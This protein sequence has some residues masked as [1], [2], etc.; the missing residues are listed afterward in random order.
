MGAQEFINNK[1]RYCLWVGDCTPNELRSMPEVMKRIQKV[2][3]FRLASKSEGTRKLAEKPT[4][5]HVEN[6]PKN[7]YIIISLCN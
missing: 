4:R 2:K 1:K 5:F 7:N 3:E 6:M